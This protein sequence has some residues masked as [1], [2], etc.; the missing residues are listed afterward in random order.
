MRFLILLL[1]FTGC[2]TL[3]EP[4]TES[5]F[6]KYIDR[7]EARLGR[8]V[9]TPIEFDK[10]PEQGIAGTCYYSDDDT[11]ILINKNSWNR[12]NETQREILI[13]HE[14]GHCE[15]KIFGH[16][17][18]QFMIINDEPCPLSIMRSQLF[19][20]REA[21]ECYKEFKEMYMEE[22]FGQGE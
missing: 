19:S 15:L 20:Y 6:Q 2:S 14:L 17:E 5:V 7:F 21:N 8:D 4:K 9:H 11:R 3:P 18:V 10:E 1:I 16:N 12:L 13:F 22:L